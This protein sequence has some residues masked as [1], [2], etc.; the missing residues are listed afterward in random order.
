LKHIKNKLSV[1]ILLY[2]ITFSIIILVILWF[3]QVISFD[4]FYEISVKDDIDSV[5]SEIKENYNNDNYQDY[6]NRLSFKNNMCIEIYDGL[7]TTYSSVSCYKEAAKLTIE[8]RDV[9]LGNTSEKGYELID[10]KMNDKILMYGIKLEN[11]K[12]AF[13]QVRLS[14]VSSTVGII[15]E[16]LVIVSVVACILSIFIA[17]FISRKISKPIEKINENAKKIVN[18]EYNLSFDEKTTVNEIKELNET[19]KI[20]SEELSKTESLR[21]EFMSNVSH[22]LKTPLTMIKAYAEM[23]RD[24]TYKDKKKRD[25]N[26]NV[27]IEESDRLNLLVNDILDLSKYQAKTIELDYQE[28]NIHLLIREIINRYNI[29]KEKDGFKIIYKNKND[30]FVKA[31]RKRIEQVIYNLLNNA[32]NYSGEDKKIDIELIDKNNKIEVRITNTGTG[33][34]EE[35][36]PLIWDK[37]YKID[38]TYSRVQVGTGIGLSI[39]KNILELHN[40]NY[41][42]DSIVDKYTTFYFDLDKGRE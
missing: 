21:R 36:I 42:V 10:K 18:G 17:I 29:Y 12:F 5:L 39:V 2:L 37:Y 35:D 9:I 14:P 23:V 31:D 7:T 3:L 19:L 4:K 20:T 15:K 1:K 40:S 32:L 8:K 41:G 38:K 6:F 26:L 34:K 16:Q 24:L 28:F 13:V 27:I 25:A 22:D 11:D 30:Y 33:I